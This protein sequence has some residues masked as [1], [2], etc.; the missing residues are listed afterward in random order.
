[1]RHQDVL[2][3]LL[4]LSSADWSAANLAYTWLQ[5]QEIENEAK[6]SLHFSRAQSEPTELVRGMSWVMSLA[7]PTLIAVDQIDAI[8]TTSNLRTGSELNTED[9][10]ERTARAISEGLA[11]GLMHLRDI[12]RH[13]LTVVSCLVATWQVLESKAMASFSGRF[14][15]PQPLQEIPNSQIVE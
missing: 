6:Q 7:A 5:G 9:E 14:H 15:K 8:V 4:L 1:M 10:E 11:G 12:K 13:A 3:A 2:R